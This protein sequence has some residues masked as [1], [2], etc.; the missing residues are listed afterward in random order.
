MRALRFH[1]FGPPEVL[2]VDEVAPPAAPAPGFATVEVHAVGVNFADTE[3][4]RGLYLA[5]RPLPR[6]SGFEGAGVVTACADAALVGRRVAFLAAGSAADACEVER[7]RLIALPD[8]LS[9]EEGAAFPVQGL[10]AW[11]VLHGVAR[12]RPGD[13]VCITAAAGGVGLLAVQLAR[14]AGAHVIG[15]TSSP[16]KAE[17]ARAA[18]AD[19]VVRPDGLDAL[20]GRIDVFLDSVGKDVFDAGWRML[21]PFGRWVSFG[22]ASGAPPAFDAERLL[23]RSLS[24]SGYWLRAPHPPEA[25]ARGVDEVVGL[26]EARQ[27]RLHRSALPL[28]RAAEAHEALERRASIG[29]W[30]LTLR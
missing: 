17:A 14:R 25:W 10:T 2:R 6:V 23:E 27:L 22:T 30:V 16:E 3:S 19:E 24:V 20:E 1:R 26:L 28:E 8:G 9:F 11:H 13:V 5:D 29:K 7:A 21:R 12:V 15:V 18:G 4:R